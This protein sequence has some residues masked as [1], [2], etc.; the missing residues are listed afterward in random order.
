[1]IPTTAT[2]NSAPSPSSL[3]LDT[4]RRLY[5]SGL[6][7]RLATECEMARKVGGRLPNLQSTPDSN[8]MYDIVTGNDMTIDFSD[9]L[10][11]EQNRAAVEGV[12]QNANIGIHSAMEQKL[13][14]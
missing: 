1:M 11:V 6:A 10:N 5:G 9:Y 12:A 2:K 8:L 14:L 4:I 13:N 3:N 7:M